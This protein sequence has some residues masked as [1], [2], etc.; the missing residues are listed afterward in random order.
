MGGGVYINAPAALTSL[1]SL[2]GDNAHQY[3]PSLPVQDD[4]YGAIDSSGYNLIEQ[5]SNCTVSGTTTGNITGLDPQLSLLGNNGGP[6]K[7]L[8][9]VFGSPVIDAGQTPQCTG[10]NFADL[11]TDQR[12][13]PRPLGA[14]CDIGAVESMPISAILPVIIK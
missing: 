3:Q 6:T 10:E 4:C 8:S 1:D 2:L 12:G 14:A 13:I 5:T 9:P 11:N 7:T